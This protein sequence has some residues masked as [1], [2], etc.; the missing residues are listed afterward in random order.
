MWMRLKN[1]GE[2]GYLEFSRRGKMMEKP[3]VSHARAYAHYFE[4]I[5]ILSTGRVFTRARHARTPH[6]RAARARGWMMGGRVGSSSRR[7]ICTGRHGELAKRLLLFKRWQQMNYTQQAGYISGM[8]VECPTL[9]HLMIDSLMNFF[10]F[11]IS[12]YYLSLLFCASEI[13]L[14]NFIL[15]SN[16]N[17][18]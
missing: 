3:K 12:V 17:F 11:L 9:W 2:K 7:N 4:S 10:L 18:Y 6:R 8:Y 15:H 13:S 14:S 16:F 5:H 1:I